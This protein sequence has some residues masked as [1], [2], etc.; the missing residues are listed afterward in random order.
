MTQ[1][2]L[3]QKEV[4]TALPPGMLL[5]DF[6][7]YHENLMGTKIGCR[8]GDC[9][10]CT[11]LSGEIK[12]GK[13]FY[14]SATSC[15]MAIGNAHGKHIVTVEGINLTGLNIVQQAFADEGA[16]Q[17]GFCTPGFI[18]SLAGYCISE[19]TPS[20]TRAIDS[21]NGNICRCTG[22]KSIERA[23]LRINSILELRKTKAPL[24]F[25]IDN[26]IIPS[27]FL[28]IEEK[29]L[30]I[31]G[32]KD[33]QINGHNTKFLGGGT[34]LYVQQHDTMA[35]EKI[36]FL[37]DRKELKG[38]IKNGNTCEMGAAATVTDIAEST[39]FIEHFPSLVKYIRLIA[40]TQIRNMATVGG[41]FTNASPIGDLTIFFLALD[42]QL[43]LSNG[44]AKREVPLRDFYK[45]YKI[46]DKASNEFIEKISFELPATGQL[47]NFEKVSKRTCLDIASVNSALHLIMN[48]D[49]ITAA[50]LSAG[51]VGPIPAYLSKSS[52]YLVGKKISTDMVHDLIEIV[53][54]EITPISDTR[55]SED[56]KRLLLSQ[57]IKA[58][59]ITLFPSLPQQILIKVPA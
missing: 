20:Y 58:H 51:G 3:N 55:G 57:L 21:I 36:G 41:N 44:T 12:D 49:M 26:N 32:N 1:F 46:L 40:S 42:A 33:E 28:E 38:I 25:A 37:F 22:Y 7:R 39:V 59:F 53:Q 6:I 48:E 29:L 10:A 52:Q 27:Y 2:I 19:K 30:K 8:E 34:D 15:L 23:A 14:T 11:V 43:V 18:V 50:G 56:Y 47:F 9:G 17:C 4:K 45:G 16:T 35:Y 13:L 31:D 5:L 54:K 24:Q